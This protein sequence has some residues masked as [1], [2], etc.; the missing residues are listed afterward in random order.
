MLGLSTAQWISILFILLGALFLGFVAYVILA[1]LYGWRYLVIFEMDEN[2]I[3]HKQMD[4]QF[5][6]AEAVAWLG[7]LASRT[8]ATTGAAL[9]AA[10][11][12]ESCVRFDRLRKVLVQRRR[13]TIKVNE[14]LKHSQV[15]AAPEDYDFVFENRS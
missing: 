3:L 1:M 2:G 9:L 8:P 6:Q 10:G 5:R 13:H 7:F 14:R 11:K 15:Y 12:S 4:A